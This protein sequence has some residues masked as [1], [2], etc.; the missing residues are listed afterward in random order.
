MTK[1]TLAKLK[2]I[3]NRVWTSPYS[4]FYRR[5]FS[6]H[7]FSPE[8]VKAPAEWQRVPF[9]KRSDLQETDVSKRIFV[10]YKDNLLFRTTSGTSGYPAAS[11]A[12]TTAERWLRSGTAVSSPTP[13][14]RTRGKNRRNKTK[15]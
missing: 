14:F 15:K 11:I 2:E 3:L 8:Q 10:P 12:I 4:D 7:N 5:H 9:L 1:E 6:K 13:R